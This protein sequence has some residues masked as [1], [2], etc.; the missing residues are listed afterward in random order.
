[1]LN[2]GGAYRESSNFA[3]PG[4]LRPRGWLDTMDGTRS[5]CLNANEASSSLPTSK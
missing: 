5:D 2:S 3:K 4:T 1:M